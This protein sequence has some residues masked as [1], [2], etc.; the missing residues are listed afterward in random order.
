MHDAKRL[1]RGASKAIMDSV[2]RHEEADNM[3]LLLRIRERLERVGLAPPTITVRYR[4]LRQAP[5]ACAGDPL[6]AC[7]LQ[8]LL[9]RLQ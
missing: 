7:A 2:M 1:S 9:S 3:P 6:K 4:E 8:M 5:A